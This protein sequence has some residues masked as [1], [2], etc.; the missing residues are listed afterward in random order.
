[1]G[2]ERQ[3]DEGVNHDSPSRNHDSPSREVIMQ[4]GDTLDVDVMELDPFAETV[5]PDALDRIVDY[6]GVRV[7]FEY[8][9]VEVSVSQDGVEITD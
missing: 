9:E 2:V 8:H 6:E 4:V 1:M 3:D 5:D 7:T